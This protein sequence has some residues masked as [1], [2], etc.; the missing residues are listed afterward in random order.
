MEKRID[1]VYSLGTGS[2]W[3]NNEIRY[4]LRSLERY[5]KGLGKIFIVGEFPLFLCKD[6]QH[7]KAHDMFNPNQNADGNIITKV[8]AACA[9]QSLSENFMF[10]NDDHIL[11]KKL[12]LSSLPA[13]HKGDMNTFPPHTW[14]LNY[15]R[16]RLKRTMEIL[17]QKSMTAYHFDC[18][19]P[20]LF[21]KKLFRIFL[22]LGGDPSAGSPTDTLLQ[23]SPPRE[24][25]N[26]SNLTA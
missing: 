23:L 1:V 4:S 3:D 18:H 25:K 10:I 2:N 22:F 13:F 14:T 19:T 6:I 21:N 7:I 11:L 20:I 17:N 24:T 26:H 15:W 12:T 9:Q 16:S 8:L 5:A